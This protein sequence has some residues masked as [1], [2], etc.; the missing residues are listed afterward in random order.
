MSSLLSLGRWSSVLRSASVRVL[1][2]S[3]RW[4][5]LTT[6]SSE[7]FVNGRR[8]QQTAEISTNTSSISLLLPIL[9]NW[10]ERVKC[11]FSLNTEWVKWPHLV[12]FYLCSSKAL[13]VRD[14]I[15]IMTVLTTCLLGGL[16]VCTYTYTCIE[17]IW[18]TVLQNH[19]AAW[20]E[21]VYII[22]IIRSCEYQQVSQG[23]P[24]RWW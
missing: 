15:L 3:S 1:Q 14:S 24:A 23:H 16:Q 18:G 19:L 21:V 22:F 10:S 12:D 5:L 11:G 13:Q 17:Y 6:S 4:T 8:M 20:H 7:L 9:R 2:V